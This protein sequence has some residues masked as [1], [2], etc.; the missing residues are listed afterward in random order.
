ML[1]IIMIAM[2]MIVNMIMI[3]IVLT[4]KLCWG[5]NDFKVSY[6]D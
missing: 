2:I 6:I 1:I 4:A 5:S 3:T